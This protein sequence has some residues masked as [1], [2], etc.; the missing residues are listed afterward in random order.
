MH[1][2]HK[3]SMHIF[4]ISHMPITNLTVL[5]LTNLDIPLT[6]HL[7]T[8]SPKFVSSHIPSPR[9][10][11]PVPHIFFSQHVPDP[12]LSRPCPLNVSH[13][14][15][16]LLPRFHIAFSFLFALDCFFFVHPHHNARIMPS[17]PCVSNRV[18][19]FFSPNLF[20][21]LAED[22]NC[23]AVPSCRSRCHLGKGVVFQMLRWMVLV[24][25]VTFWREVHCMYGSVT[26]DR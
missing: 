3:F 12:S 4:H 1:L 13:P 10:Y 15:K 26:G 18:P 19:V 11:S 20:G 14:S 2:L 9:P 8:P 24:R 23:H 16:T 7:H 21:C 6:D 5:L 17:D 22:F 25:C